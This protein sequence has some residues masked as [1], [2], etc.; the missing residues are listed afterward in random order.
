ML[1]GF[2]TVAD[3]E[4]QAALLRARRFGVIE[5]AGGQFQ[6]VQLR[7]WPKT[8]SAAEVW[9]S[10]WRRARQ[11]PRTSK[12]TGIQDR[13]RLFYNQPW[14]HGNFLALRYVES[15]PGTSFGS[16]WLAVRLLDEIARIKRSDALLC[17]VANLRISDRLLARWGW[18]PH[19]DQ[20]WHRHFIKRFYGSYPPPLAHDGVTHSAVAAEGKPAL[21]G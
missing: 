11:A 1:P 7:P 17:D 21:C 9:W 16:F 5:V 3:L 8:I 18:Q 10:N 6:H 4:Q 13:C 19:L 15:W 20:R 12:T 14:G 2:A